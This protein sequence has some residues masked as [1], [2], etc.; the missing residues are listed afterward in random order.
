M[1]KENRLNENI[2]EFKIREGKDS[3][4]PNG[5]WLKEMPQGTRFLASLKAVNDAR[6]H[7]FIVASDPKKMEAVLL[8][9]NHGGT[10]EFCFWNPVKFVRDYEFFMTLEVLEL[11]DGNSNKIQK[12]RV[13]GDGEPKVLPNLHEKE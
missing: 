13:G 10:G 4:P 7:D 5:N 2:L 12:G 9:E 3:E 11:E 8:G 1:T 6:L